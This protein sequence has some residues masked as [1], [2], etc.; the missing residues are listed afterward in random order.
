M[1]KVTGWLKKRAINLLKTKEI[2]RH[3]AFI[4]DGN[5]RWAK[6]KGKKKLEGH[7]TGAQNLRK[8]LELAYDLGVKEMTVFALSIDN[9]QRE[10]KEVRYLMEL[11]RNF[12]SEMSDNEKLFNE[13][14]I[15]V[16]IC[17][18][19]EKGPKDVENMFRSVMDRT[20]DYT[21]F[22]LNVCFL[23]C[24]KSELDDAV[25]CAVEEMKALFQGEKDL[26]ENEETGERLRGKILENLMVKSPPD[27][28][29]RTGNDHR[30]SKFLCFQSMNSELMFL[31]EKWPEIGF[32]SMVKIILY[33]Q[34]NY[35]KIQKKEKGIFT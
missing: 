27:M 35:E 15:K 2:P 23:Y 13:K 21:K 4:M 1:E 9:L 30:L 19:L 31:K 28:L 25:G 17:G 29:I 32:L 5:R 8:I 12:F 34:L 10:E 16:N 22:T 24:A 7:K 3:L 33:Y 6:S 14:K 11:A 18:K 20:K 26:E